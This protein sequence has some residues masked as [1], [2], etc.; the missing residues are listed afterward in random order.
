MMNRIGRQFDS[1]IFGAAIVFL[2]EIERN[3]VVE[4]DVSL[5]F[6]SIRETC[7]VHALSWAE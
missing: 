4:I 6:V 3:F 7:H 2:V 5:V 1:L